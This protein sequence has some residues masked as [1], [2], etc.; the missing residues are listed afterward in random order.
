[1]GERKELEWG[2]GEGLELQRV[3]VAD[4]GRRLI[5]LATQLG[6]LCL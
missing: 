2:I 5:A 6:D 1:M 3:V 4:V